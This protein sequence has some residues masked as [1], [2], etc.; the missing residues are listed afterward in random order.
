MVLVLAAFLI[1]LPQ[2]T[3]SSI[4]YQ[5][6]AKLTP[7]YGLLVDVTING[8]V[9]PFLCQFDSG[10]DSVLVLD[11]RK[12]KA[13][14][15]TPTSTGLSAGVGPAIIP[16]VRR[17][18]VSLGIGDLRIANQTV[19]MRPEA[20]EGCVFGVGILRNYPVE[21]DYVAPKIVIYKRDSFTPRAGMTSSSGRNSNSLLLSRTSS[22][23]FRVGI[24][25]QT[26]PC[27][28]AKSAHAI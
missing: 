12:A 22:S 15:L 21:I 28:A 18:D 13:A 24:I 23:G 4:P 25:V 10:A 16:D 11:S 1:T 5:V 26:P 6:P 3:D 19:V 8:K 7:D 27:F 9:G 14:G 2:G 17:S 20:A